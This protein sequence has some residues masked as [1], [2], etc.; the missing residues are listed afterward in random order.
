MDEPYFL[1][2]SISKT[3]QKTIFIDSERFTI[4]NF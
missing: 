3:P 1:G 2:S 4:F